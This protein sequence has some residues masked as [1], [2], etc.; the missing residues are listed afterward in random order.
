MTKPTKLPWSIH[1]SI[2]ALDHGPAFVNRYQV[3]VRDR[4]TKKYKSERYPTEEEA[5]D[6]ATKQAA[7]FTLGQD[8]AGTCTITGT[9]EE[10]LLAL[11]ARDRT[12]D[13][14]RSQG[15]LLDGVVAAGIDNL[16]AKGIMPA[17]QR[18][19]A[20][21]KN[22]HPHYAGKKIVPGISP[23]TRKKV[24]IELCGYGNWLCHPLRRY[25]PYNPF[26][27]LE[28][29]ETDKR[30]LP[31]FSMDEC[32]KLTTDAAMSTWEGLYWA[33]RLYVGT[34]QKETAWMRWEHILWDEKRVFVQ[35]ADDDDKREAQMLGSARKTRRGKRDLEPR[36][37]DILKRVKRR[38]ERHAYL[39]DE[40]SAVLKLR[41]G[42]PGHYVFPDEF[43]ARAL[44]WEHKKYKAHLD[45]LSITRGAKCPHRLRATHASLMNAAGMS[46]YSLME[47]M[48][49]ESLDTTRKY[50]KGSTR[51]IEQVRGWNKTI[52]LRQVP[53][54]CNERA[55]E[56]TKTDHNGQRST[57]E[58]G[59]AAGDEED[60]Y[61]I[62]PSTSEVLTMIDRDRPKYSNYSTNGIE[63]P[64]VAGSIPAKATIKDLGDRGLDEMEE[65]PPVT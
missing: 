63:N 60:L 40:F 52:C 51:Y 38:K 23:A 48:G 12:P 55:T 27:A 50:A 33:F 15:V 45:A 11:K 1:G 32:R 59:T 35:L 37:R 44:T 13:Y 4:E 7:K 16:R 65:P 56:A 58:E 5:K 2:L 49:H 54:L 21:L 8:S 41:Q 10:Y 19:V 18:Y 62:L 25:L 43:R 53:P 6:W 42:E 36:K 26:E 20:G 22:R 29:P 64:R 57:S 14:I 61:V 31:T 47:F 9:K 39:P 34:R 3:R 24:V 17:L 28:K 46:E 30:V